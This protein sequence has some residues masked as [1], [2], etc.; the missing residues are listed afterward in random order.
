MQEEPTL[1]ESM[2]IIDVL[3]ILPERIETPAD[4]IDRI[5]IDEGGGGQ[6]PVRVYSRNSDDYEACFIDLAE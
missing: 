1:A 2:N 3:R 5:E 6:F 4:D